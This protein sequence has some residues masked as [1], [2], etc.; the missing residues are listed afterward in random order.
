MKKL[1]RVGND[2][3]LVERKVTQLDVL[4]VSAD[5]KT[6]ICGDIAGGNLYT[7]NKEAA[8][9]FLEEDCKA[10]EFVAIMMKAT[11]DIVGIEELPME[12]EVYVKRG[13]THSPLLTLLTS[14]LS[15]ILKIHP[16]SRSYI[17]ADE[18]VDYFLI[19]K[20]INQ[21]F[22]RFFYSS[23]FCET[24]KTYDPQDT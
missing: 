4:A 24:I 11:I 19:F 14:N 12:Q 8:L 20:S 13:E 22:I 1:V 18:F 6:V 23:Y 17:T 10:G 7:N 2:V 21:R 3:K 15:K 16:N 9:K 5:K